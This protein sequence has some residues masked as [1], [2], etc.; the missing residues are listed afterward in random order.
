MT[1]RLLA[2]CSW[3]SRYLRHAIRLTVALTIAITAQHLLPL[4]HAQWIALTVIL[5]LR[6]DFAAHRAQRAQRGG[7]LSRNAQARHRGAIAARAR[8]PHF[9]RAA[10]TDRALRRRCRRLERSLDGGGDPAVEV[11][12]SETDL[13]V[14]SI[15]TMAAILSRPR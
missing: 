2:N 1:A 5:V 13:V 10:R 14:D 3:S 9:R 7:H 6:P 4:D 15:N 8:R 11:L 12:V